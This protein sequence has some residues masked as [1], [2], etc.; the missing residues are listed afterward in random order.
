MLKGQAV[1]YQLKVTLKGA[2]PPIWRRLLVP[3]E[4]RLS[5]LHRILQTAMGWQDYHLHAFI[6]RGS[7]VGS[8][9]QLTVARLLPFG[10]LRLRYDYDFGDGWEHDI[11]VEKLLEPEEGA[12]YPRCIAGRGACPPEDVGGVWGYA[13]FLQAIGDPRHENHED[14]LE[15]V[16]GAFDPKAFDADKVNVALRKVP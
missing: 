7:R 1:I 2:S 14:L 16:G 11:V 10:K 8:E 13:E 3:G 9:A 5:R 4:T 12:Q 15:W 6:T